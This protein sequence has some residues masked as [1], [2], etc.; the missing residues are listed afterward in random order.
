MIVEIDGE[1][2]NIKEGYD[3]IRAE[4]FETLG[5]KIFKASNSRILH[6]LD[7]VMKELEEYIII[8]YSSEPPRLSWIHPKEGN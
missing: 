6:D 7:N 1:S 8:Q 2:Y 5:L 4:Y 3:L